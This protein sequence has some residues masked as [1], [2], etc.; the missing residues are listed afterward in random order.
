MPVI[1]PQIDPVL[2]ALPPYAVIPPAFPYP[3]LAALAGR[4][5]LG[6]AREAILACFMGAR[7]ARDAMD[8]TGGAVPP[9]L[10]QARAQGARAWLN[11]LAVPAG[12]RATVAKLIDASTTDDPASMRAPLM[13]VIAVTAS[14]LD[15][16][17][18]SELDRLAQALAG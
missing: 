13:A 4:A 9:S 11:A 14:Y 8:T 15:S 10:R 1:T 6:G 3:A 5:P 7:L 16:A 17:S 12:V 18:R 2:A